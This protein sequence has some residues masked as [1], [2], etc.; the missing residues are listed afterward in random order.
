MK[1][2]LKAE[3]D[4]TIR[5]GSCRLNDRS[6]EEGKRL[7]HDGDTTLSRFSLLFAYILFMMTYKIVL[8]LQRWTMARIEEPEGQSTTVY[9]V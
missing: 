4:L 5:T 6:S 9:Y 7:H 2:H 1:I 3:T 8:G